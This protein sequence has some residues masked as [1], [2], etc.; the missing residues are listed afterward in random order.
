LDRIDRPQLTVTSVRGMFVASE[1]LV[2]TLSWPEDLLLDNIRRYGK[3]PADAADEYVLARGATHFQAAV[4]LLYDAVSKYSRVQATADLAGLRSMRIYT[5]PRA[6]LSLGISNATT[7]PLLIIAYHTTHERLLQEHREDEAALR[8]IKR[9]ALPASL[10]MM[11]AAC[12]AIVPE[13]AGYA[14][15]VEM[16]LMFNCLP[17]ART[18]KTVRLMHSTYLTPLPVATPGPHNIVAAIDEW[19]AS[20]KTTII[21]DMLWS[22]L[23]SLYDLGGRFLIAAQAA[24]AVRENIETVVQFKREADEERARQAALELE[25]ELMLEEAS[26]KAAGAGAG[27][28]GGKGGKG[29]GGGKKKKK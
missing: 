23:D 21:S 10:T 24:E 18:T 5:I 17:E 8:I 4:E 2:Y 20:I 14:K 7:A 15:E 12:R 1:A 29:K 11:A 28:G 6:L 16:T 22:Q 9:V 27:S 26:G 25:A 13:D 19:R 3:I